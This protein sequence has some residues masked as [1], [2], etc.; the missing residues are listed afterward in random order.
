MSFTA[1]PDQWV[2]GFSAQHACPVPA[3]REPDSALDALQALLD[4]Q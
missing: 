4:I 2:S 1:S 3:H